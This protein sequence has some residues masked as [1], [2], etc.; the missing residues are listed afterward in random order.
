M[1]LGRGV[2]E[3]RNLEAQGAVT[4]PPYMQSTLGKPFNLSELLF[5]ILWDRNKIPILPF[6][7]DGFENKVR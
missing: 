1:A 2:S 3:P 5:P 6:L 7:I 4:A